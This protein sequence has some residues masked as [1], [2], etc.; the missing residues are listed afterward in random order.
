MA[1]TPVS[2][3][4]AVR[5]RPYVAGL[6]MHWLQHTPEQR[7][8]RIEGSLAF[9]DISGF[10]TLTERLATKGKVGAE[11]M[12]DLLDGSFATLLEEAYAY[13]ASLVKWGGDAVLLLFEGPEHPLLASRAAYAM[14]SAM[15]RTGRLRTSVGIVQLRMSVGVHSG[16]FDFFL[17]GSRHHELVVAGPAASTTAVMEQT[18][19]AGEIVLSP[20]TAASLPARCLGAA[21]GDGVL[22]RSP[23]EV[24]PRSRWWGVLGAPEVIGSCLDPD[25]CDHLLT[26]VGDS[27]HRQVAVGF[28]E[29]SGLDA[30]LVEQGPAAVGDTLHDLLVLVQEQ[31]AHHRVTFWE[32]DISCDGFKVMLVAGAPMSTGHDEDGLLRAARAVLDAHRG[33]VRLR[34]GVNAGRVFS[35]GFGPSFRRTWSV[36]GDAVN[37]AARVMGKAGTGQLLATQGLLDRVTSL[38]DVEPLPPFLVKGKVHPVQASLVSAAGA[39]GSAGPSP[40]TG[41]VGREAE[42]QLVRVRAASAGAGSGAALLVT[43]DPGIGKTWLVERACESLAEARVV[44]ASADPYESSTPYVV[45]RQLLRGLLGA[46]SETPD[47]EVQADVFFRIEGTSLVPLLPLLGP[48]LGL[49]LPDTPETAGVQ[50][51]FRQA[52]TA[53]LVV[54]LV[55]HLAPGPIVLVVDDVHS[56]DSASADAL[57]ALAQGSV[58]QPWLLLLCGRSAPAALA[59]D[60]AVVPLAVPPLAEQESRAL[61]LA[62]GGQALAPHVVRALVARAEGNPLFLGELVAAAVSGDNEELPATLE[63]LLAAQIDGLLPQQRQVLRVASVLGVRFEDDLLADLLGGPVSP[64]IWPTLEH[65]VVAAGAGLRRFRTGLV[66]DAAYEG[67]PFRRRVELHGRAAAALQARSDVNDDHAEALSLHNLA[68]QRFAD[69]WRHALVAGRRAQRVHANPEALVFYRRARTAARRLPDLDRGELAGVLEATGDVHARLAELEPAMLAYREARRLAPAQDRLLRGR[70]ALSAGLVAGRAGELSRATRWLQLAHRDTAAPGASPDDKTPLVELDARIAVEQAFLKH[71][72][73]READAA[74]LC[75]RAVEQAESI[76]AVDVVGRALLLMDM[77]DLRAGK[78]GDEPRVLRALEMFEQAG[79]L[80]RQAGAWNHLG[81]TSYFGGDWDAA[82]ERYG[83]A[84][85]VHQRSGDEWSAA[86]A[87]GNLGELLVDQGRLDEAEPLVTEALRVWRASGTPSDIGFGAA[88]LGRLEARRQRLPQALEL[89]AQA[90]TAFAAKEELVELVDVDLRRAEALLLHGLAEQ[91]ASWL[92]RAEDRLCVASRVAGHTPGLSPTPLT[93][94]LLRLR[95][96]TALQ[97][98][99]RAAALSLLARSVGLARSL[100]TVHE[101]ALSLRAQ[102]WADGGQKSAEAAELFDRLGVTW[103]PELPERAR[104]PEMQPVR[105]PEGERAPA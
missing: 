14:R 93:I 38:V 39:R 51:R 95:G 64:A 9:V 50:A 8:R 62:G 70:V 104:P 10:T 6:A 86:I 43:G 68:A 80:P 83:R 19:D 99:G 36:K 66:R 87:S 103:V 53:R 28:L 24:D 92:D 73:G 30:L 20:Q 78:P 90:A 98:G 100:G 57:A 16:S 54:D 58:H 96:V 81:M 27:E 5:L 67:L 88:L 2:S 37:L 46:S 42:L 84:Q 82:V 48:V 61:V 35:G 47:V 55:A 75:R 45:L 71:T 7:H 69:A 74:T 65:F 32:T 22:L 13:G 3:E 40:R 63:D 11:E 33:P 23:P 29:V 59:G 79:D 76:G 49:D 26:E 17:G 89:L 12:S 102:A 41:F 34:V 91:A 105:P 85:A 4:A 77:I 1:A 97:L 72:V 94:A 52:R 21:K 25:I 101:L 15:R 56:T 44:R 60:P 18:A 31:C